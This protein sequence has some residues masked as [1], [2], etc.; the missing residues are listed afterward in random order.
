MDD[1]TRLFLVA[2]RKLLID[3]VAS[4]EDYLGVP[5]DKSSLAKRRLK[6]E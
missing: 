5:Y 1:R 4:L 6:V 3:F 2:A